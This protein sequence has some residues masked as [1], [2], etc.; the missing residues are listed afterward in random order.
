[1]YKL[2]QAARKRGIVLQF[3]AQNF[4]RHKSNTTRYYNKSN[5]I[6]WRVEWVFPNVEANPLKFVDERCQEHKR[7]SELLDKF[8]NPEAVPFEGSKGLTFYKSAGASGVKILLTGNCFSF[9]YFC[10][11]RFYFILAGHV[12]NNW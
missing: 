12:N 2:K 7:L 5:T 8:L 4:T 1:M 11:C 9:P 6:S 3:L 10:L